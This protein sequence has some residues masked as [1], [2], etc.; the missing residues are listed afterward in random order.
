MKGLFIGGCVGCLGLTMI[1]CVC[2]GWIG[3][4]E[5]GVSYDDPGDELTS[6]PIVSG[7][8]ISI[9]ATWNGTGY[10]DIRLYTDLG[11]APVGSNVSGTFGCQE[12][13]SMRTEQVNEFYYSS[14][15][16]PEGWVR[17]P[18]L[19][20]YRRA[21]PSP[22]HCEGVLQLP[23]ESPTGRLVVTTRQRPSDWLSEW[24]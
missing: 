5:E 23:P 19:Y 8:P 3:Y 12:Y 15:A 1:V 17:I 2:S 21:S 6:V 20:M 14:S 11:A 9:D 13:G 4:L 16:V 7:Q 10:A 24:F 22:F 18:P